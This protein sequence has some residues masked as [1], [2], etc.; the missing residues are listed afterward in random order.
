[1]LLCLTPV[2]EYNKYIDFSSALK[3]KFVISMDSFASAPFFVIQSE[4]KENTRVQ[5]H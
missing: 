1:M 3:H 2:V 5:V 4:S